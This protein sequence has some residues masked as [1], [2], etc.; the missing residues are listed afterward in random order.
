M[1][2]NQAVERLIYT[3]TNQNKPNQNDLEALKVLAEYVDNSKKEYIQ[4]NYLF[5]KM[6]LYNFI[7]E[8]YH[9]KDSIKNNYKY[10]QKSLRGFLELPLTVILEETRVKL[11]THEYELYAKSL[12]LNT[13][14]LKADNENDYQILKENKDEILKYAF[15]IIEKENFE[16]LIT[17]Q[18][19]ELINRY[20]TEL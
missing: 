15:G 8:V 10:S 5:A 2:T 18:I 3:V 12:G 13:E 9:Y 17:D 11:N 1:T 4:Q 19:T 6:Y 16:E 14:H 7:H 20:K